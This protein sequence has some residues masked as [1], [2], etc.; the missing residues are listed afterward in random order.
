[1]MDKIHLLGSTK[2]GLELELNLSSLELKT[3]SV[4]NY[5]VETKQIPLDR[6]IH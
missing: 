4:F 1:M 2:L 3:K 6:S 5:L